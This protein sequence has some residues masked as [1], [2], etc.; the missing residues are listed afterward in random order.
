M[1]ILANPKT[2]N[3][4]LRVVVVARRGHGA[5]VAERVENGAERIQAGLNLPRANQN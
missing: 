4:F 3:L 2:L 1:P 5:T